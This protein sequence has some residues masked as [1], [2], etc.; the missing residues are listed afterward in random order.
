MRKKAKQARRER[1]GGD[2]LVRL[3]NG[4]GYVIQGNTTFGIVVLG[5]KSEALVMTLA[6]AVGF[7]SD[8]NRFGGVMIH[9]ELTED[10]SV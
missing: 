8:V 4:T 6:D 9:A 7:I 1:T 5:P 3:T 10:Q 2:R